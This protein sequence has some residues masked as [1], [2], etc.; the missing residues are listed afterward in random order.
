[1]LTT[2]LLALAPM[3]QGGVSLTATVNDAVS[4]GSLGDSFLSLNE[5]VAL[6]NGTLTL[7]QLGAAEAAQVSGAA[8]TV[9]HILVDAAT[10]TQIQVTAPVDTIV[11]QGSMVRVE[12]VKV[13]GS[14]PVLN[15]AGVSHTFELGTS[16]VDLGGF[17]IRGGQVGIRGTDFGGTM[18]MPA[19]LHH[20]HL[21]GQTQSAFHFEVTGAVAGNLVGVMVM[22][23]SITNGPLGYRLIDNGNQ[24]ALVIVSEFM[25]YDGLVRGTDLDSNGVGGTSM[26]W[27]WRSNMTN[28]QQLLRVRR[29][30]NSSQR[31]MLRVVHGSYVCSG[32][33]T[34]VQGTAAGETVFHHHHANFESTSGGRAYWVYPRTARF[35][36]HGSE[37]VFVGDVEVAANRFTQRIW[38]HNNRFVGSRI[39]I[40]NDG[41]APDLEWNRYENCSIE[42]PAS[43]RTP[44]QIKTCELHNT[45][46]T[47]NSL[48]GAISVFNSY[49]LGGSLSGQVT[50]TSAAPSAWFGTATVLP[51][52][53]SLGTSI[54][55]STDLPVGMAVVWDLAPSYSRPTTTAYPFRF[56][57]DPLMID[58]QPGLYTLQ[59]ALTLT[60][61][62]APFL[63]GLEF[64]LQPVSLPT[65]GQTHTPVVHLPRGGL[66]RPRL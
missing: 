63:V 33:V 2:L 16:Q 26:C 36:V 49:R 22:H 3:P 44:L 10:V 21:D 43:A 55:L 29:S 62:N 5:A 51:E 39:V 11:G 40:D 17:E 18:M 38:H 31:Q 24:G 66:V 48:F 13:G 50:E 35:D 23:G 46:V 7:A 58:V 27:T 64:Y 28:C 59:S 53:P 9:D 45:S 52:E 8:G 4:H 56:Y 54:T 30:A 37:M 12:G 34:D 25:D 41:S 65:A 19:M 6:A 20:L 47:G 15:A 42:V 61:P 14:W 57:G 32:D 60:V 1:M